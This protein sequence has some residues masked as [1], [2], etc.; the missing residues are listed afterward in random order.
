MSDRE[1]YYKQKYL[2]YLL[3]YRRLLKEINREDNDMDYKQKEDLEKLERKERIKN[4]FK[5]FGLEKEFNELDERNIDTLNNSTTHNYI[6]MFWRFMENFKDEKLKDDGIID[7]NEIYDPNNEIKDNLFNIDEKKGIIQYILNPYKFLY[8]NRLIQITGNCMYRIL[9]YTNITNIIIKNIELEDFNLEFLNKE[10]PNIKYIN[11]LTLYKVGTIYRKLNIDLIKDGLSLNKSITTLNLDNNIFKPNIDNILG[12]I[13]LDNK[14]ISTLQLQYCELSNITE[15]SNAL[16]NNSTLTKLRLGYNKIN[17]GYNELSDALKVNS[18]LNYLGLFDNPINN[19][20]LRVISEAL[21]VNSSLTYINLG[22]RRNNYYTS[23]Y[24]LC[25]ALKINSSITKI[26]LPNFIDDTPKL[27]QIADMLEKNNTLINIDI[28]P[29][30]FTGGNPISSKQPINPLKP[31][32]PTFNSLGQQYQYKEHPL[33]VIKKRLLENL[34]RKI[35]NYKF[36]I[37]TQKITHKTNYNNRLELDR[38]IREKN[39]LQIEIEDLIDILQYQNQH[40]NQPPHLQQTPQIQSQYQ[41]QYLQQQQLNQQKKQQPQFWGDL[42][43]QQPIPQNWE[44]IDLQQKQ[45]K[46]QIPKKQ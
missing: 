12:D 24:D 31:I 15:I 16:K 19:D 11:D 10:L 14:N 22:N 32:I 28:G 36:K 46:Q 3:K 7:I 38:L 35:M 5:K 27:I 6:E 9:N 40:Q 42:D 44:D 20:D 33:I 43:V 37:E 21:K 4:I 39:K 23:I 45:Q 2:K 41:S 13:L 29:N 18:S 26:F 1:I 25:E 8:D 30:T 17:T 34:E